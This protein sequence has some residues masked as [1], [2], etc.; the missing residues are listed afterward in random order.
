MFQ[1]GVFFSSLVKL[2]VFDSSFRAATS[3]NSAIFHRS[4]IFVVFFLPNSSSHIEAMSQIDSKSSV[5]S[6]N[7]V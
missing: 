5:H 7:F 2:W 3:L 6:S 1:I 4:P